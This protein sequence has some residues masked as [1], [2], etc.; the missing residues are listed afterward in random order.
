MHGEA[1]Q[2]WEA[3]HPPDPEEPTFTE[4]EELGLVVVGVLTRLT[5]ERDQARAMAARLEEDLARALQTLDQVVVAWP[6]TSWAVDAHAR[7]QAR[8]V[9]AE[10]RDPDRPS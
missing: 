2:D 3:T 5:K 4:A 9:L 1:H 10:L 7:D 8:E 6:E